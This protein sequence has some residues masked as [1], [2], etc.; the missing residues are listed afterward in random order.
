[1][2]TDEQQNVVNAFKEFLESNSKFFLLAAPAGTGKTFL[3]KY[4]YKEI[5]LTNLILIAKYPNFVFTATTH[6]AVEALETQ[7]MSGDPIA[8][9]V[10]VK[11]IH[12]LLGLEIKYNF[13]NGDTLLQLKSNAEL[14]KNSIIIIDECSMVDSCLLRYIQE[15]TFNC[16]IIFIGDDKQLPPVKCGNT[17]PVFEI[18]NLE[19][20]TLTKTIRNQ[21]HEE[22]KN[23]CTQ[24]R[25]RVTT[26]EV[27]PIKI[28]GNIHYL[29]EDDFIKQI[30]SDFLESNIMYKILAY[31]NKRVNYYNDLIVKIRGKTQYYNDGD[32]YVL[33]DPVKTGVSRGIFNIIPT[34][35]EIKIL[36]LGNLKQSYKYDFKYYDAKVMIPYFDFFGNERKDSPTLIV[37]IPESYTALK[38][39]LSSLKSQA[40]K[41][42]NRSLRKEKWREYFSYKESCADLRYR[43]SSTVHKAQGTTL[44]NVYI[45]LTDLSTCTNPDTFN[46]LLYVAVSRAKENIYFTGSLP[47]KYGSVIL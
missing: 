23:L 36:E 1:M 16:K 11:T 33:A 40:V 37:K 47:T 25:E 7:L 2:L 41:E 10:E 34:D 20:H 42:E 9:F 32:Y 43:D 39:L 5:Y 26:K 44:K 14:I 22:L 18:P 45:D 12:S 46:K 8:K 38:T 3:T 28:E 24:L 27:T 31:T 35:T 13:N 30:E 21:D 4:L 19:V 6:K 17:P 15:R 29:N